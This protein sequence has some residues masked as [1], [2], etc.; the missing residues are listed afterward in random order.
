[1][2]S[3]LNIS[4]TLGVTGSIVLGSTAGSGG[5]QVTIT[6]STSSTF[7]LPDIPCLKFGVLTLN[8][9]GTTSPALLSR[10][11]LQGSMDV[12]GEGGPVSA[13]ISYNG[14]LKQTSI[15]G[16]W[17]PTLPPHFSSSAPISVAVTKQSSAY[18][19]QV[20]IRMLLIIITS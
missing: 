16:Q 10:F 2:T 13:T 1:M 9:S 18:I 11:S 4:G 17:N 3:S 19:F 14:L 6:G 8:A 15:S 7:S 5:L 12:C 20:S